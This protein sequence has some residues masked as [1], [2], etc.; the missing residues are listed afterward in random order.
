MGPTSAS[1]TPASH[2]QHYIARLFNLEH[3]HPKEEPP[4][5]LDFHSLRQKQSIPT[6]HAWGLVLYSKHPSPGSLQ[7]GTFLSFCTSQNK[8]ELGCS[9][10]QRP[11]HTES[12]FGGA[13]VM[14][15]KHR[16]L[17]HLQGFH[18]SPQHRATPQSCS[19]CSAVLSP[20][21]ALESEEN[22]SSTTFP[23][24]LAMQTPLPTLT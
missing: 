16:S 2:L 11:L 21:R 1:P 10:C 17:W 3:T 23:A 5:G 4:P 15:S 20:L 9:H 24:G 14:R 13:E 19:L 8:G 22:S 6:K 12:H 7:Q 18:T